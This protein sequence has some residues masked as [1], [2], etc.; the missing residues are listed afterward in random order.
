MRIVIIIIRQL[1]VKTQFKYIVFLHSR[2]YIKYSF[3]CIC[4][5]TTMLIWI[6]LLL[7]LMVLCTINRSV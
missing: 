4:T 7:L 3:L 5:S 1:P 2:N 6:L